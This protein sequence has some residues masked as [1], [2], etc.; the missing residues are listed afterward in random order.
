M[1]RCKR[2]RTLASE[3]PISSARP[4]DWSNA[5]FQL[6]ARLLLKFA[7]L[8][9]QPIDLGSGP[10]GC[11]LLPLVR[12]RPCPVPD[13]DE[14]HHRHQDQEN[15]AGH[16]PWHE[17]ISGAAL[18]PDDRTHG[19]GHRAERQVIKFGV[20]FVHA[21]VADRLGESERG[22]ADAAVRIALGERRA[23]VERLTQQR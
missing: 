2:C 17:R 14:S 8:G 22:A 1:A 21:D 12:S 5:A 7:N 3:W 6:A 13:G 10:R 4:L 19:L 9:K 15:S 23:D 11:D 18:S 20:G 16:E